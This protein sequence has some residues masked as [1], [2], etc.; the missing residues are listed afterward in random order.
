MS[1]L[2][3]CDLFR[4]CCGAS[5]SPAPDKPSGG[6]G[7]LMRSFL[8]HTHSLQGKILQVAQ[9]L[10]PPTLGMLGLLSLSICLQTRGAGYLSP[11]LC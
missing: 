8:G 3:V 1:A 6:F 4:F 10:F 9:S 7:D 5:V 2:C 11:H